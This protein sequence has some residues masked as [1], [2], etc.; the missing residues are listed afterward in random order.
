MFF[1]QSR[2]INY[3]FIPGFFAVPC[4]ILHETDDETDDETDLSGTDS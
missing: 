2:W 4:R 3:V 1:S